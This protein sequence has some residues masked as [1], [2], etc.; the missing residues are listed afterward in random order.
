MRR[1]KPI[2]F[3]VEHGGIFWENPPW[4]EASKLAPE[5]GWLEYDPASFWGKFGLFSGFSLLVLGSVSYMFPPKNPRL[6][7]DQWV[8]VN[9]TSQGCFW[10]LKL[11]TD[12]RGFRILRANK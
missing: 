12:L 9:E 4:N 10:V 6:D 5:N 1:Q 3:V 8:R 7:P 2:F 11:A